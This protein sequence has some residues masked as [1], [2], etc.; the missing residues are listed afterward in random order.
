MIR[1]DCPFCGPRDMDEF[2]YIGNA[3]VAWPPLDA[4]QEA[5]CEAVFFH[6]N[7]RGMVRELWQHTLGC[8]SFLIIERDTLTH[9]I[10]RV[11]M[12]HPAEVAA[13]AP[14]RADSPTRPETMEPA[15]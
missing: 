11:T 6:D 4:P 1:I 5:W 2:T 7:P 12:A 3:D 15:E 8:R 14:A 10:G 13:L 9:E